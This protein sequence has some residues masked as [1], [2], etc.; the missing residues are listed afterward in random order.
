MDLLYKSPDL[1]RACTVHRESVRTWGERRAAVVRR[2]IVQMIAA[3]NLA[4]L[5]TLP[6]L[7]ILIG[8]QPD[9]FLIDALA[10]YRLVFAPWHDPIPRRMD[11]GLD[12]EQVTILRILGIKEHRGH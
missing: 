12:L 8:E 1:G 2:R 6:P 11:G 5:A 9:E 4:V 7:D 3:D 10:P